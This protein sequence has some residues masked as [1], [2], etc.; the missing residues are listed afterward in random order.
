M[1]SVTLTYTLY[2]PLCL[3][4][5]IHAFPAKPLLML[6]LTGVQFGK[7]GL[8][9]D[10]H[11]SWS[12]V[13]MMMCL[14]ST[15]LFLLCYVNNFKCITLGCFLLL[16]VWHAAYVN[17]WDIKCVCLCSYK[18]MDCEWKL[19]NNHGLFSLNRHSVAWKI[20][21]KLMT[22]WSWQW[23]E[24]HFWTTYCVSEHKCQ[25]WVSI[26]KCF[27]AHWLNQKVQKLWQG[28][29]W[30]LSD[31]N[32]LSLT[33]FHTYSPIIYKMWKAKS[34]KNGGAS[35][36]VSHTSKSHDQHYPFQCFRSWAHRKALI[37]K[38][39]CCLDLRFCNYIHR[40][41]ASGQWHQWQHCIKHS[42]ERNFDKKQK[43]PHP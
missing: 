31:S 28:K 9:L 36:N 15:F 17:W 26:A 16:C 38:I 25:K 40:W 19:L 24:N 35:H 4:V 41:A 33:G 23:H 43:Y 8:W 12:W 42:K 22:K 37:N 29:K 27:P 13:R 21:Q 11:R 32:G 20:L 6:L 1:V 10:I 34:T 39:I 2:R 5:T 18:N 3:S 30:C 7:C 14:P